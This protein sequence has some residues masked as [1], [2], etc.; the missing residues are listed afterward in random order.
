MPEGRPRAKRAPSEMDIRAA[1]RLREARHAQGMTLVELAGR[2]GVSHQQLQKYECG[3]NR[4]SA[5][6]LYEVAELLHMHLADFFGAERPSRDD[7]VSR[8]RRA[9][10]RRIDAMSD[11]ELVKV[12][13]VLQ[14][15]GG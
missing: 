13:K 4:I 2:L 1:S 8:L 9:A 7:Q 5:G 11:A 6:M 12:V 10:H 3:T 14:A 15:L